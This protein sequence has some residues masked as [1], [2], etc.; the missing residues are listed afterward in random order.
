MNSVSNV[1]F[2]SSPLLSSSILEVKTSQQNSSSPSS[3][4]ST[5]SELSPFSSEIVASPSASS[6]SASTADLNEIILSG[7]EII[8]RNWNCFKLMGHKSNFERGKNYF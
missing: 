2:L 3:T 1:F 5:L 4:I 8:F 7:N 6:S